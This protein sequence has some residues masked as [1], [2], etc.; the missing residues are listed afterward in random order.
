MLGNYTTES[1]INSM[2]QKFEKAKNFHQAKAMQFDIEADGLVAQKLKLTE[3]ILELDKLSNEQ[4]QQAN[5]AVAAIKSI[6]GW[7]KCVSS[8]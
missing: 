4:Y 5:K 7:T 8:D 1:V 3:R 2:T 6:E